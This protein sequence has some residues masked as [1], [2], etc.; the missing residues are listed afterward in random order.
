MGIG[1]NNFRG[2]NQKNRGENN[3][4]YNSQGRYQGKYQGNNKASRPVPGNG[5]PVRHE[6]NRTQSLQNVNAQNQSS[7]QGH[8]VNQQGAVQSNINL[9]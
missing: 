5:Q 1:L 8:H 4:R 3:Q 7:T 6:G 9:N 2:N